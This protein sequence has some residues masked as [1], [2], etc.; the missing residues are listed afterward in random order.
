MLL[1]LP[2]V[3]PT[4]L[5]VGN[6]DSEEGKEDDREELEDDDILEVDKFSNVGLPPYR[7]ICAHNPKKQS[8]KTFRKQAPSHELS[9]A[10]FDLRAG[11]FDL[12][13]GP[14]HCNSEFRF[15]EGL[16]TVGASQFFLETSAEF[17]A[18]AH[19]PVAP[20]ARVMPCTMRCTAGNERADG[21]CTCNVEELG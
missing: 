3:L 2:P 18:I 20:G 14:R 1:F 11:I 9:A 10:I 16:D 6:S 19:R 8:E 7:H 5:E 17:H 15:A 12:V 4:E 13:P 21:P